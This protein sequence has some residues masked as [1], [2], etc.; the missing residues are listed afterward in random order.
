[1]SSQQDALIERLR[2]L[3]AG[4]PALHEVTMF[5][6]RSFMVNGKMAVCARRDGALLA[7]VDSAQHDEL[8]ARPGARQAMMG[9]GRSMSAGWIEVSPEAIADDESLEAWVSIALDH[10]RSL[11]AG[12]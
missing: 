11:S 3:L 5:G 2:G 6:V 9:E 4:A 1:M 12:A 10:N 7:R 8:V